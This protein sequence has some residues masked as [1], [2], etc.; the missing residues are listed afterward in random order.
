MS[1][2]LVITT[3][4]TN[5]IITDNSEQITYLTIGEQGPQGY[6]AISSLIDNQLSLD[7]TGA[8]YVAPLM[9]KTTN[10]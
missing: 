4:V 2:T 1:D 6:S 10:W 9:W 7:N 8:L 5:T 3:D